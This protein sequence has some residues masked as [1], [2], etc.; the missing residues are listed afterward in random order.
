[1]NNLIILKVNK[2]NKIVDG[3]QYFLQFPEMPSTC[4]LYRLSSKQKLTSKMSIA[5][6]KFKK[7][8]K[9]IDDYDACDDISL[10]LKDHRRL[11]FDW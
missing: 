2:D 3:Y 4:R 7:V 11:H 1:M 9:A 10:Y 8:H 5:S 6:F